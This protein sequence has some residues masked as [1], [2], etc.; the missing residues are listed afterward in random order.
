ML[1]L[2]WHLVS[3]YVLDM[4]AG[5]PSWLPHPVRWIGGIIKWAEH[6]FY[7]A[8]AP[9]ALQRLG[10]LILWMS[11]VALVL[12]GSM[13]LIGLAYHIHLYLGY[14][15]VIWL[16]Y[17]TLAARSLHRE[18]SEV[19]AA[20]RA[21]DLDTARERLSRLVSRDT[22]HLDE[23]G[24][25][26]ALIE[27]VTEN[28]SDGIVA[29]IFYL[30]VA[31]PLGAI[32]YK[33]VNT[34]DSMVGY[35]N[36]RYR[37]FGW[38]PARADDVANWIPARLSGLLLVGAAA[39]Y[40]MDWR[41]TWRIMRRDARLLKSPNA[42]FPEAAAAGALGVQLGGESIY[43]GQPVQKPTLGNSLQPIT[44]DTYRLAIRLM[45]LTSLLALLL[46]ACT[47]YSKM[48]FLGLHG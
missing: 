46:A 5:D 14:A 39:C 40:G 3:A 37:Y 15:V 44:L 11:V 4:V 19:A 26:R 2:P 31:G 7:D 12:S 32:V 18:S 6:C 38:F 43:F 42:G 35:M 17:T 24:I 8:D 41:A 10:G 47:L 20:L 9:S 45:Y 13:V 28:V 33:A 34:M 16:A 22:A 27:T 36:E 29:P 1:F 30:A 25:L 23:A 21:L 48:L